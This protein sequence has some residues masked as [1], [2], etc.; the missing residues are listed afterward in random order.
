MNSAEGADECVNDG[1]IA[2]F[3]KTGPFRNDG[4]K[5][6][7]VMPIMKEKVAFVSG[8][9]DKR[10][11]P[12]LTFPARSNHDRIKQEDLRQLVTYLASV[13]SEDVSKRGFTVIIDMRGSKWDL[14]KPLLKTLQESFPADIHVA[15]IIKPDNFWQKQKTNFGSSKFIFETSMVSVE[16]LSKLV[17]PSQLTEEFDGTLEY[18]HDEWIDLRLALEEFISSAVHL[19]SRLEDLQEMLARKEFPLD[20]EGSRKLIDEHT[21]L[22][23]KVIKAPVE[24]LDHEG[25]RLLQCI[26]CSDGFSGKNCISGSADFQSVVPK[27]TSLL[28]KLH[29]TRQHLHQMWHVRKLKLD[30]CFQLRLFEQ[31]AEKMFDWI[32]HN[33]Q[34]F[35][36]SHTEI[37][38]SYQHALDLQTQHNHFAMNSMNAYVN[39]NRIMSVASRLSEAGHYAS[40]QIKQISAQLDQ[41]WKSFAAALDERSTILAMSAVFHQKAEQYLSSVDI[42]CKTCAEGGLPSEMQDLEIAIHHHQ[43]LYEQIT[44]AYAEVSQDGKALLD[45]LQRPLSP[46]NSESLTAT[47]NYSKAVH[48]VLD[49]VHEVLHHQRRLESIWQHRKVRLHQRLQLCVFQQDVQQVLDWIENHGEAFLSKHTGVGKSLHRA[50]ALQ[51]RH[52][53]FEEVAQNTYTNA[54]KLLE[55][56]EQLAQTGECDPEEIYKAARHLEVRIQDFVRRV[57]HR[58]LLL[59]MSVS[60]HTHTKELWAWMEE[61]QKEL[62]E[63]VC[64]DSVDAVQELIKQFQQ[65]QTATLEATLNVIKE[66]E[67]LIQQLRDSAISNNKT[68]HNSSISHIES[69]LQQLD[70]AQGQ[71][72]ELFHERKIKLDIFL[73]LRIFEQY[74]IEVTAELDAWNEDLLHQ[75]NDFNTEDLTLAEQRLQ[76]HTERKL[77]MNNMTFDVIQQGQDLH[78]YIMEVQASGIELTCDKDMDLGTQVQELLEFLHDKQQELEL[79]ADQTQKRLEQC[80]QL[81][82]L[83]AEVKQVLGWIR[84]GESMLNAS[85]VNASSLS[86]AEQLQREHEQ[87]QLAIEKTHQSAL[88]VQQKAETMLQAGHYDSDAIR[89]CAEKVA[90]H[91]QQ[92][93]L[94]MEDRLK[95]VNASVAFYKT[96]EQVCSVLESLEQ[97]YRRDEDWC[98]G[99][100]KLGPNADTD[101]VTPLISK[102]LEQKE[103]FLKACTLARRNAEVFLKYIHRNNVSMPGVAAHTRGPEQQVKAILSELLQREN[104][105][106]HFWTMKKRRLDQCQQYVVFER[107]AKQA[108]DWIQETGEYYL[109]T[110]T[111]AGETTEETQDL[112]KEYGEFRISA[113]QTKEKV[114][115]I[116]QLADSFV[117]KGHAHACEIKKWVTAVD[118]RYRDFSLRMGKYKSFLEKGLG[119]ASE[120]NKD[121]ELDI[122]PASLTDPEVKLRDANHEANEE[123]RKSARKK[124]FIM[125]ELLQTEKA[126]VRDLHECLETYFWEMTCGVEEIPPGI[127]NKEHIIFG[128]IQEIYEFHNN[129]FLKELEKY[130]QL[131]EDVGHCFVTWADKFQMYVSYCKNKPDSSQLILEHAGAFFDEIQ[132]RHGLANSIS[133][134]LIKPVQRITKYQLLLKELLTCCEEGKGELKDGLEVMLSVPK[135]ANDAMHVS[136]LEG[137]DENFDVQGELILQD[138]FQVWD[139]KSLIRKGR[140]RHLF[141]FELSLVFS[142]EIKD[143]SGHSKYVYKHKLLTSELGV[144]EHVEGDPCKF[145]LWVGRTPSSDN[146]TVLKASNIETKQDWIKNIREVIQERTIHLKGALKEPI[147][148]PKTPAKQR[149]NSKRDMGEDGDSQGDGSSQPDTISIASRTSQNTMDSDKLSGGCELT[150]VLQ[151]FLASNS[152]E[153]SIQIGQTVELLERPSERPGWCLVRTTDRSPPLEGLVPSSTLCISHS[154]SSVEMECFFP[155]GKDAYSPNDNGAKSESVSNLQPQPS[156]NSMQNSPGPKRSGNTLKKWLTSPVRRLSSGK[157][158]NRKIVKQK[159]SRNGKASIDPASPKAGENEN[160][161]Q[162]DSADEKGRKDEPPSGTLSKSSSG[163]QSGGEDEPDDES[164]TPLPP[165]MKIIDNDPSPEDC[166][167]LHTAR[168]SASEIPSAADLVSAIEKLVK[169]KLTLEPGCS[170]RSN[171]KDPL[172]PES[173]N[174]SMSPGDLDEEKR[175][176]AL[177]GR[178]YVLNELVQTEKDYVKD[179]GVV[180]EGF[181]KTIEDKGVPDDM[182]GKEKI[183][184]GNIHQIYDWHNSYFLGELEKSLQE[185]E[186]LAELFIKHERR[187]GMYVVYCQNKPK[188]EYIVAEYDAF[189]EEIKQELGQRLSLSDFLIKPIQ[190]ITKY[191]L[192]IKDFL[193]YS[194]KAG[195]ECSEIEKAADVMYLVPKRCNDMMNLGRLE[196]FDG[197]ITAQGKLLQQDTFYVTEQDSGVLSRSKERRVFLFEQIVIFSELL[198]KG[199]STPRYQ[200]KNSIK[201]SYLNIEENVENE[202]CKFALISRGTSERFIL[203]APSIE[204]WQAWV[205][206]I[207]QVLDAQRNFLNALQSPI[208]YMK[209]ESGSQSLVKTQAS[210]IPQPKIRALSTPQVGSEK[211]PKSSAHNPSLPALKLSTS[212]GTTN[213]NDDQQYG[214]NYEQIKESNSSEE[215]ECDDLDP[216]TSMELLNPN[217]IHEVPPEFLI[218]LADLTCAIGETVI[219]RCKVCGRPKPTVSWKG[220]DQNVLVNDTRYTLSFSDSGEVMLKI[221]NIMPQDSGIYSCQAMNEMG[222]T[223]SSATIKVQGVPAAP[224]RPIAQERSNSSVILRWLPPASTGNCTIS[225]YTVEYREEGTLAWQQSVASTLDTYLVI[226]DLIPGCQYQF[227]VS[228]SNPWGISSPSEPSDFVTLSCSNEPTSDDSR[229]PWKDNFESAYTELFE[230]GRGRFSVV[231][232]CIQKSTKRE[233]AVKFI[234]K[235]MKKKDQVAHEAAILLNLQH[236]QFPAICD[237]YEFPSGYILVLELLDNGRLLEFLV[238]QGEHLEEKVAFYIRDTLEALQYLHNCRVAHLDLKPENLLIDLHTPVPRVKLIDLGDAVQITTYYYVHQLLGNP[239]FAAPEVIQGTPVSLSTDIWSLGV[240]TYVMLSGVSPFLD[241][242]VEETCMNICRRDFSFPDEYFQGISHVARDFIRA[243][244][245]GDFRWRPTAATCLQNPWLHPQNDSYSTTPLDTSRLALFIER[246]RHQNDVRPISNLKGFL[247]S[248]LGSRM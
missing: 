230:I 183:V 232:K 188:S 69:V 114:K 84:N 204:V 127:I 190:R 33:K 5:V 27:I 136:M 126:Y 49:I 146:K 91:W 42:W 88:Q 147:Q 159:R 211:P 155:S 104:R 37:G 13:P 43:T 163:M 129:I 197:K 97:E 1:D 109:S 235:K 234:S 36:Q 62:L 80:L 85:L 148:L 102:H 90:L 2:A 120:D 119:I 14:I 73:Q 83:Q 175:A 41:E 237:T 26:R 214:D 58:K 158:D 99:Q 55:A 182:K 78:Q 209:K 139:P 32:S 198:N 152:S 16:G 239:E 124:E 117:E 135:R 174:S 218:P 3:F 59:D 52:D 171:L 53:D 35:L 228:A 96:S 226:E 185:P 51:K 151:D 207:N 111:S 224:G 108:L 22:K 29:S 169:S 238:N 201:M 56:A 186:R 110:H 77:A 217:F 101:H 19:L 30:Q 200:F 206:D 61:L 195:L 134:Y 164:H 154:R 222:S 6:S 94:K 4:L 63:D 68:P 156:L 219:L 179:L 180:V 72:E 173:M 205:Q 8:G 213:F 128:N 141:L 193:K 166:S 142:K 162:E 28:D 40:Q 106:L 81:R 46:G 167:S 60:F 216:K 67:D 178:A 44:Q 122:I 145:A 240:L 160:A 243:L 75:M 170:F 130:E 161:P 93:M 121:L 233:V 177:K 50:R 144:T 82:H 225:S 191:Q 95:L 196:D 199:S 168:Q 221:C 187:L 17:D 47:A 208:E 57:E 137:F 133:S 70:E 39:I 92:L 65:Q 76:R 10:G 165:P 189:F 245:Q 244:L 176:K 118:K 48:R 107:S 12:I 54:D 89:E 241:E 212:N 194:E 125:A 229:I 98:R 64:A 181:M 184:F 215:S 23:K 192:L 105:V 18:N 71:M 9:R 25:Q 116:I 202:L 24:E 143:S 150:V 157:A 138:T 246:R 31:D 79:N 203:Q 220:P 172:S 227:R 21:Q 66:G 131:P 112:M 103:A 115:L 149:N 248:N 7:D 113:Q 236:P 20:V 15:L 223:S 132:Q 123:K 210:R 231:K 11:G 86:E 87:F 242:S 45:V 100:D 34:L 140:E 153:L 38:V 247:P 74:T